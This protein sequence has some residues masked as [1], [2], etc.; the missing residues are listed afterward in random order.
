MHTQL[1]ARY[2]GRVRLDHNYYLSKR[3]GVTRAF[4]DDMESMIVNEG[5]SYRGYARFRAE[6]FNKWVS[7]AEKCRGAR[8]LGK[9][10][11]YRCCMSEPRG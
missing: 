11:E 5:V 10:P 9:Q 6:K 7:K 2:E 4:L 3:S 1:V 8:V